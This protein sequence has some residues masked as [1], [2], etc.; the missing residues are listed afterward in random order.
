MSRKSKAAQFVDEGYNIVVTGRSLRITDPMKAYALEKVSKIEKFT[1]RIIDVNITMD[2]QRE[3]NR[4]DITLK[5]GNIR[6]NSEA[7]TDN[8]YA[9]IDKAVDKLEAQVRKH[10]DRVHDH[11]AVGVPVLEM[12]VSVLSPVEDELVE[13]NGEI[14]DENQRRLED[15]YRPHEV[16]RTEKMA[17][18]VLNNDEAIAKMEQSGKP[19]LIFL[20]EED[21][22][23]KVI[24]RYDKSGNFAI[25]EPQG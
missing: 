5:T 15:I 3:L 11:H 24:Y 2:I 22:K 23:L 21:R 14:E 25:V 20:G 1:D 16:V 8:M 17:L 12:N 19:F 6:I 9:S 7:T 18:K 4:V 13:L 10:Q